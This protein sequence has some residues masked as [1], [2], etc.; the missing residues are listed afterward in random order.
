METNFHYETAA[1]AINELKRLGYVTDFNLQENH[2]V[3]P[4]NKYIAEF[5]VI[6][7]IYRYEGDS[8]PGD[9]VIIYAIESDAGT[10]GIFV[11]AYGVSSDELTSGVIERL[12]KPKLSNGGATSFISTNLTS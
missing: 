10:K 12:K 9:E 6:R 1:I 2:L 3:G 8:D 4:E 7:D 11:A 5:F